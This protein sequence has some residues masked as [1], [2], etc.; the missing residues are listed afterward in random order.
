VCSAFF[1]FRK[2]SMRNRLRYTFLWLWALLPVVLVAAVNLRW[3]VL[4]AR[5]LIVCLPAFL[6]LVADGLTQIKSKVVFTAAFMAVVGLSI[7]G[8]FAYFRSRTDSNRGDNWRDASRYILSEAQPGDVVVFPYS[9]EEIAFREYQTRFPQ[10]SRS[11]LLIPQ[12]TNLELLST[13]G[14]WTLP[15]AAASLHSRVWM[16]SALQPNSRSRDIEAALESRLREHTLRRFGFVTVRLF[17]DANVPM[18]GT[19]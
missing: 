4:Q 15:Q 8:V 18:P 9:A 14:Q 12:E 10:P 16:I 17:V 6:L 3:P 13:A 1:G 19:R 7:V 11:L 2:S 5:Y